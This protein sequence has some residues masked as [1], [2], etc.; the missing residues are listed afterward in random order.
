LDLHTKWQVIVKAIIQNHHQRYICRSWHGQQVFLDIFLWQ[1]SLTSLLSRVYDQQV[2]LD[3]FYTFKCMCTVNKFSL[4]SLLSHVYGRHASLDKFTLTS[5][6]SRAVYGQQLF[7]DRLSWQVCFLVCTVNNFS[8]TDYL[9]K[10]AFSCVRST[11]FPWQIILT[12]LLSRVQGM[13]LNIYLTSRPLFVCQNH[14]SI[15]CRDSTANRP[16]KNHEKNFQKK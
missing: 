8:L 3:K 16:A 1:V 5:L 11:T 7:L 14:R 6:L 9:D 13:L 4:T 2:F 15:S 12:S 10:F